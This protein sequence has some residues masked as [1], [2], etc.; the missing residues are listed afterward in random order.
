MAMTTATELVPAVQAAELLGLSTRELFA[1]VDTEELTPTLAPM[2]G[3]RSRWVH[4]ARAELDRY[5]ADHQ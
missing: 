5:Q 4:F 1:L 2:H 3:R